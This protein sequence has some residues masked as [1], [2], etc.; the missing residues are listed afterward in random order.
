MTRE[1]RLA[2]LKG[3]KPTETSAAS[4]GMDT[5]VSIPVVVKTEDGVSTLQRLKAQQEADAKAKADAEAKALQEETERKEREAEIQ[6]K[7]EQDRLEREER[8]RQAEAARIAR[9]QEEAQAAQAKADKIADCKS[10][11]FGEPNCTDCQ[12]SYNCEY[13]LELQAKKAEAER[14][15]REAELEQEEADKRRREA[16]EEKPSSFYDD[17]DYTPRRSSWRKRWYEK[18]LNWALI[19]AVVAVIAAIWILIAS[20]SPKT[21]TTLPPLDQSTVSQSQ[22]TEVPQET[23]AP[24]PSEAPTTQAPTTPKANISEAYFAD[25]IGWALDYDGETYMVALFNPNGSDSAEVLSQFQQAFDAKAK[26]AVYDGIWAGDSTKGSA[27]AFLIPAQA[28]GKYIVKKNL[29]VIVVLSDGT[30][31]EATV[32]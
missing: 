32:K 26:P 16:E 8:E 11:Y 19:V 15:Q 30:T 10:L 29:Q 22:Q 28:G 4:S 2:A 31:S 12:Y 6:Q 7:A 23:S 27:V 24:A 25:D 5:T 17:D 14:R 21:S 13:Q 9:E 18:P 1:E 3:G 20:L